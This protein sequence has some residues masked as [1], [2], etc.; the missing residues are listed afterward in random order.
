MSASLSRW[1]T[2][3]TKIFAAYADP[4]RRRGK[5]AITALIGSIWRGVPVNIEVEAVLNA[6][7]AQN[8]RC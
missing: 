5:Q 2:C 4:D 3:S 8:S 1:L 7:Q 6:L